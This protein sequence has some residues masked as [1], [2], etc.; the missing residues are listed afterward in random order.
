VTYFVFTIMP[1]DTSAASAK[2]IVKLAELLPAPLRTPTIGIVCGS[3]LGTLAESITE[4]IIIPYNALEGFAE[5]T[6]ASYHLV[7][8]TLVNDRSAQFWDIVVSS[9]LER[10]GTFR[11]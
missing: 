9:H 2:N 5:S 11:S 8:S 7:L 10:S 4:R 3:G 1:S 6:G